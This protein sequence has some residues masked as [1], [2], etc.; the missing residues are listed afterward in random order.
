M[1]GHAKKSPSS[2]Y[3]LVRCPGSLEH[4]KDIPEKDTV[5]SIDGTITHAFAELCIRNRHK[6]AH[7]I[8]GK[9]KLLRKFPDA[10]CDVDRADRIDVYL[11]YVYM[12]MSDLEHLHNGVELRVDTG[13]PDCSGT[14]DFVALVGHT[15]HVVDYKDGGGVPVHP[16][17]NEQ[18]LLYARGALRHPELFAWSSM[19]DTVRLTIVQPKVSS[20]PLTH[21]YT[22][23]ELLTATDEIAAVL[24]SIT[25]Q[26][27]RVAGEKQCRFCRGASTCDALQQQRY[28]ATVE[29]FADATRTQVVDV[30]GLDNNRI[31]AILSES[32]LIEIAVN[33]VREEAMLRALRGDTIPGYKLVAGKS[34]REWSAP[35]EEVVN[36][37]SMYGATREDMYET[38]L[39]SIP[40]LEKVLGKEGKKLLEPL[41]TKTAG[42]PTLVPESD[43]RPAIVTNA[44][45]LFADVKVIDPAPVT[46]V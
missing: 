21:D 29:L 17:G 42:A 22:V 8:V 16:E 35:E 15:L 44:S 31:A 7:E 34:S 23:S 37:C 39:R 25:P 5:Y 20:V 11:D 13:I 6:S 4:C 30:S 46:F 36:L 10:V 12:L 1:S 32:T 41:T 40:K 33:A 26:S 43:K 3:R 24:N 14:T 38:K 27:P 18:M 28:A 19:I 45:A 9:P 2:V